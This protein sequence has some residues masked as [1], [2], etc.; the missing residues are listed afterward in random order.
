MLGL[1]VFFVL[2]LVIFPLVAPWRT[3]FIVGWLVIWF[4]LWGIFFVLADYVIS[5][6][7]DAGA[8][9]ICIFFFTVASLLRVVGRGIVQWLKRNN[10]H[11]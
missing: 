5:L 1:F 3:S 2:F 4:S 6:G 7:S 8:V 9:G 10:E 11:L